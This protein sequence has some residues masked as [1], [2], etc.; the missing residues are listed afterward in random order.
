MFQWLRNKGESGQSFEGSSLH[1]ALLLF[2]TQ[3]GLVSLGN[4]ELLWECQAVSVSHIEKGACSVLWDVAVDAWKTSVSSGRCQD[5]TAC[6]VFS[7]KIL[8]SKELG[9][10]WVL[11]LVIALQVCVIANPFNP[12]WGCL[13]NQDGFCVENR[14]EPIP[15]LPLPGCDR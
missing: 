15:G 14:P 3:Q 10:S 9:F 12:C 1:S 2:W 6:R 11:V 13:C 4:L 7:V 8:Y 5:L